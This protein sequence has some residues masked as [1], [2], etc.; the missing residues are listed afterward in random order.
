MTAL[1]HL[2]NFW[3]TGP[4]NVTGIS[5]TPSRRKIFSCRPASGERRNACA[6]QIISRLARQAFAGRLLPKTWKR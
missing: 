5:D 4:I 2:K 6:T 3:I 1:P